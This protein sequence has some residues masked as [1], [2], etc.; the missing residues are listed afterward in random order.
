MD[1]AKTMYLPGFSHRLNGRPSAV[2][3]GAVRLSGQHLD[4]LAALLARFVPRS[5]FAV[6][7]GQRERVYSPW[8]TFIAFLSQTLTRGNACREAVRRVQAWCRNADGGNA[9]GVRPIIVDF[10]RWNPAAPAPI[11]KH[12]P[13]PMEFP[14]VKADFSETVGPDGKPQK[15]K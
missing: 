6:P 13:D 10:G 7:D 12:R 9:D 14:F 5:L 1:M 2:A 8:V 3:A 11:N 15:V 4:G